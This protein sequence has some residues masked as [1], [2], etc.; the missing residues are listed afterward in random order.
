M[1]L[2]LWLDLTLCPYPCRCLRHCFRPFV[3]CF[4]PALRRLSNYRSFRWRLLS[5]LY[6]QGP[7]CSHRVSCLFIL[8]LTTDLDL[9]L[10][11]TGQEVHPRPSSRPRTQPR[12]WS[13]KFF[14]QPKRPPTLALSANQTD[15]GK[16]VSQSLQAV[17]NSS[18]IFEPDPVAFPA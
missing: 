14:P 2:R 9:S 6:P 12:V 1:D 13:R 15:K 17:A 5:H 7:S 18:G 3:P 10:I 16:K 11:T 4:I 8:K